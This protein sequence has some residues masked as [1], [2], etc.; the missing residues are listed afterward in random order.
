MRTKNP[1]G[2]VCIETNWV[3]IASYQLKNIANTWYE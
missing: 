1:Q 2:N 3:E